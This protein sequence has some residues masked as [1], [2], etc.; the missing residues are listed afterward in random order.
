M[1]TS[2]EKRD[3]LAEL[4]NGWRRELAAGRRAI[5]EIWNTPLAERVSKGHAMRELTVKHA[6]KDRLVLS[7]SIDDAAG[8][9][10]LREGD[11]V[12]LSRNSPWAPEGK[13]IHLGEDEDGI[14]LYLWGGS[15]PP[16]GSHG[17]TLDRDH[18]DLTD[19]YAQA[20]EA[21]AGTA[22]GR[23]R[24]LP[25][26]MSGTECEA[27]GEIFTQVADELDREEND[28]LWHD[29]Q[30]QAVTSC[31]AARDAWLVQGH[32]GTGKTHV[33]S[34]VVRRLIARGERVLVTGPTHRAIAH[35]LEACR[36]VIA[37]DV[38]IVKIGP[39][40]RGTGSFET[41]ESYAGSGL[42]DS[43]EP[44]IVGA[45]PFA[46]WS[47]FAGLRNAMFDTVVT[48]EA[49]QITVM[50]A[51]MA[52]LH[53]E[54]WLFFG[55]DCQLPP[56][57][58]A[59]DGRSARERS[60]FGLLKNRGFDTMLEETWRL[61]AE[62]AEWPSATFYRNRLVSRHDR[63]LSLSPPSSHPALAAGASA[64]LIV[65]EGNGSTARSDAE[66]QTAADVARELVNS[67]V[68]AA[69]IGVV[70]PFRAQASRVRQVLGIPFAGTGL[71]RLIVVDTVERF[72]G[73][74]REVIIITLA[75]SKPEWVR[76]L[77]NFLFQRER[78]N[79]A[80]TRARRK[81]VVI[82]SE[83]LLECAESLA[84]E[85]NE[86]AACF[87]SWRKSIAAGAVIRV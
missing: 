87:S 80:I 16:A 33:L 75:S 71:C 67:G 25:L 64:V 20:M 7:P 62:L 11:F 6:A 49:S 74:E 29:S 61:N 78:W 45:T 35:A 8:D 86:G 57:V 65:C 53:G 83:S 5:E 3:W 58:L 31:M 24:I 73:Q 36:K 60:V 66:A 1:A 50:V 68:A 15:V 23:D 30:K 44:H 46:L 28:P 76:H 85:G 69:D 18:I 77:A 27:D 9:C 19:R 51:V 81:V 14:H 2:G 13:F 72:Q 47:P 54:R 40:M 59:D 41:F 39:A 42:L 10:R 56:V 63:R 26:L 52:M 82:A 12:C 55:D 32:P 21:L 84:D 48:D 43:A 38:R 4:E 17:W 37:S 79:V 22:L 34:E 70:T